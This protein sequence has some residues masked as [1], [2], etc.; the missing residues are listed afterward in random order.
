V[1]FSEYG[2]D[3]QHCTLARRA[4][5]A[6][7]IADVQGGRSTVNLACAADLDIRFRSFGDRLLERCVLADTAKIGPVACLAGKEIAFSGDGLTGCTLAAA[8]TVG[9]FS[10]AAETSVG[11]TQGRLDR[12]E[13]PLTSPV[14]RISTFD[15]PPGTTVQL[16][17]RASELAWLSVP[18]DRYVTIAGVKL[19]GR[20]NFDCGKFEYGAAF[21]DTT[22]RGRRV[23]RGAGISHEDVLAP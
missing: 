5:V 7:E 6:A 4:V 23:S 21:E 16:C 14:L 17:G 20:M 11:F 22:L 2:G 19:T 8:Q 18:E 15:V 12:F 13:M 9:P 10:L 3:L 1:E